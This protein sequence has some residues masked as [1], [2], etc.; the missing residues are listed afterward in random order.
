LSR[1]AGA[2]WL[3]GAVV[4]A[5]LVWL[6]ALV[7]AP[8]AVT[9][10]DPGDVVFRAGAAVYVIGRLVCHQDPDRSFH[11]WHTQL[12]VCGRC[13]GIYCGAAAGAVL[14]FIARRS[15]SRRHAEPESSPQPG[16]WRTVVLW[17]S[18]PVAVS[19]VMEWAGWF[20]QSTPWRAAT[21]LPLGLVVA[22]LLA[23]AVHDR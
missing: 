11:V 17:S 4:A 21:G 18:L 23:E 3:E 15:K 14:A 1:R 2:A 7:A 20:G 10:R 6:A 12:P 19:V 16:R 13:T 5:A 8:Y 22:W 9:H